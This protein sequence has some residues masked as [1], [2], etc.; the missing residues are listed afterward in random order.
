MARSSFRNSDVS[1]QT[2]R[3]SSSGSR[4]ASPTSRCA[5][6]RLR[7]HQTVDAPLARIGPISFGVRDEGKRAVTVIGPLACGI[8]GTLV[9]VDLQTGRTHRSAHLAAIGHPLVGD[10]LYGARNAP[11]PMLHAASLAMTHPLSGESLEVEAP[12]P[13]DFLKEMDLRRIETV[14]FH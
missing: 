6:D 7:V 8:G 1:T 14:D 4:S 12:L 11:R 9:A 5:K 10:W 2:S 13:A 3:A